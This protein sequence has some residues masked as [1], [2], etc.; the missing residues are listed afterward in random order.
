MAVT[1]QFINDVNSIV[2]K[3]IPE[4]SGLY[5]FM[6]F[7][8]MRL[9]AGNR[10]KR[11]SLLRFDVHLADHCNLNCKGCDNFSPIAPKRFLEQEA[12]ENDCKR[13]AELTGGEL[14]DICLLGGEPLLHT[15][16]TEIIKTA[17]KYFPKT[18]IGI[19]T[20]GILL[21]KMEADFWKCCREHDIKITIT[22]YPVKIDIS[23]IKELAKKA[24]VRLEVLYEEG[25]RSFYYKP[26]N[27]KGKSRSKDS[28]KN[29]WYA[30]RCIHLRDGKLSCA[31]VSYID[32]LNNVI[33]ISEGGEGG[34]RN[35]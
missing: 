6:F 7:A 16:I 3:I 33:N 2:K 15:G 31:V 18:E 10:L 5:R 25:E 34:I 30:N 4:N 35:C 23:L 9:S 1:R 8:F 27:K 11:R 17:R 24:S 21:P 32:I 20:N 14:E 29:C 22:K 26:L 13:L 28:F 19:L 12:F